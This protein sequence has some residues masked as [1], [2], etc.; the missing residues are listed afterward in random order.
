MAFLVVISAFLANLK[1]FSI[2]SF[3]S[4][5]QLYLKK[6]C[7]LLFLILITGLSINQYTNAYAESDIQLKAVIL[8]RLPSFIQWNAEL[9]KPENSQNFNLCVLGNN[10]F[11]SILDKIYEK[12]TIKKKTPKIRYLN[13]INELAG[14]HLVYIAESEKRDISEIVERA[15][16]L[17][18]LTIGETDGFEDKGVIIKL[19]VENKKIKFII[20]IQAAKESALTI[21]SQLLTMSKIINHTQ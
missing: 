13:N 14:C 8:G 15:K 4:G 6:K 11:G 5:N 21:S 12:R 1:V 17:S 18:I 2:L 10:P 20:N 19:Y 3:K 9:Y 7:K 16:Q